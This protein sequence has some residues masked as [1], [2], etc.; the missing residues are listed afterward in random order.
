MSEGYFLLNPTSPI[1][2]IVVPDNQKVVQLAQHLHQNGIFAKAILSPT[3]PRGMERIR[4]CLH[5]FNTFEEI[6]KLLNTIREKV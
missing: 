4:I 1:Q 3:V 6:D 2:G 5:S